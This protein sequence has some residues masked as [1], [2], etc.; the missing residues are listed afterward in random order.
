M[1]PRRF[2]LPKL[3]IAVRIYLFVLGL[4]L[5]LLLTAG[6]AWLD[7]GQQ[8]IA[9]F[10]NEIENGLQVFNSDFNRAMLDLSSLG[11]WLTAQTNLVD[12]IQSRNSVA[13]ARYLAPWTEVNIADTILVTDKTGAL[14]AQVGIG[15]SLPPATSLLKLPGVSDALAGKKSS[16]LAPDP[17][18]RL[19]GRIVLPVYTAENPSP[20][21]VIVL[22]FY[23][24]GSFLKY[25][26]RRPDQE[27]ALIYGDQMSIITLTDAQG[28]PWVHAGI[29]SQILKSPGD[30]QTMDTNI[31]KYLFKFKPFDVSSGASAGMYGVGVALGAIDDERWN[32]FRTFGLGILVV[33][34]GGSIVGFFFARALTSPIHV[35]DAAAQKMA[36]GDLSHPI[37]LRREDEFGD[38][39]RQMESMRQQLLRALES[40]NLEKSRYAAVIRDMGVAA[41]VT[42]QNL[43][44]VAVNPVAEALL[45]QTQ[46]DL[47]GRPWR[48][49][50]VD[51]N[52]NK[53]SSPIWV[54]GVSSDGGSD[55][56]LTAR[57]R[58]AL[59]DRPQ[60]TLEVIATIVEQEGKPAGYVH[61]LRDATA[62]E[63]LVRSQDEFIMNA[64]H[65]LRGPLASLRASIE[66]LVEDYAVMPNME[67]AV[68]LR[69]LQ[70]SVVKFQGLV[71]NIID[72]GNIQAGRFRVRPLPTRL[73]HLIADALSQVGP[74]L[75]GRA[76]Q[77][78][79]RL[80][81]ATPC[82]VM[83]DRPRIVQVLINLVTNASKYGPEGE[84][85]D[86]H[87]FAKDA[88]TVVEVTDRGPGIA[89]EEQ[90][91]IFRRF[92]R[93]RRAEEEGI[94][95]GLGL[96]LAREIITAHGG[97][98][99]VSSQIGAGTTF[100]FS[101]PRVDST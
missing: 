47:Q 73:D 10:Q 94:G 3:K 85:I 18:N 90:T 78:Q 41:V 68:M 44:V 8:A 66:L 43:N 9:Q 70:R 59:R 25:Q 17:S 5:A 13:L 88:F 12:L 40:A 26:S 39:A 7:A 54:L 14:L 63:Q 46:A 53:V 98:I 34:I 99:D 19:Q 23:V 11:N 64:A 55:P 67:M 74:L 58:L 92:Y 1:K 52:D 86:L 83:A 77:A 4:A 82:M 80:D 31:G 36:Q 79:V 75:T 50:F 91:H 93:G 28:K 96:A 30:F 38:L 32:L 87:V 42:D 95:I 49:L 57:A 60:V 2:T 56:N 72:V 62:D 27:I 22:G 100:W 48:S 101:L 37:A 89:P 97:Q 35:L 84:R 33:A 61:I 16:G 20:I 51:G 6:L 69:T 71:E 65:E 45:Q 76:Q 81:C 24:D 15:A 29:P 21:G